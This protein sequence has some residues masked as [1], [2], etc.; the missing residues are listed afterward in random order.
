MKVLPERWRIHHDSEVE[1]ERRLLKRRFGAAERRRK[2]AIILRRLDRWASVAALGVIGGC[3][4]YWA[5][6]I[7]SPWPP[8]V[9]LKHIASSPNCNAARAVGLAPAYKGEPGY[10]PSHDADSDGI[11]CEPWPRRQHGRWGS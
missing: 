5:V 2:L 3:A 11:A 10:W 8:L 4:L 1:A 6:M 9:L 7:L